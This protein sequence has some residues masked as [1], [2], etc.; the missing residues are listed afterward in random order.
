[1]N[2]DV[3]DTLIYKSVDHRELRFF[4]DR[5][6]AWPAADSRPA[7]LF[8]HGGGWVQGNPDQFL[9]YSRHLAQRV[10]VG[11]RVEYRLVAADW[12]E[13]PIVCLADAKSALRF[14]RAH[15]GELGID[16]ARIAAAGGSAGGHLAAFAALV[17]GMDEPGDD[18]SLSPRPD[19][20]LLFN[21]VLNN[22]P[23]NFGH[24]RVRERYREF[25]PAHHVAPKAPPTLILTGADD[26]TAPVS[27]LEEFAEEIRRAG[28]RCDLVVYPEAAHGFFN[29]EPFT[30][31]TIKEVDRFL[32]S[33]G[34]LPPP[35]P[36]DEATGK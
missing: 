22:G 5:P 8:F 27:L 28:N 36:Q 1:M 9:R 4:L 16:P 3:Q 24:G 34:W 13:P 35:M 33:L 18:L 15:A 19:A 12:P 7:V 6:K 30:S 14:A 20:L 11:I 23:G 32:V 29:H 17:P 31:E 25:S 21:P 26:T 2:D 10:L